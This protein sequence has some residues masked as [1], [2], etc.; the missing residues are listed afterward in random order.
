MKSTKVQSVRMEAEQPRRL[1]LQVDVVA[2][3]NSKLT[4]GQQLASLK[5]Q[6]KTSKAGATDPIRVKFL[7]RNRKYFLTIFYF[8]V[9]L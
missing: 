9:I 8:L 5:G 2:D 6:K 7:R 4:Q 3:A 1:S